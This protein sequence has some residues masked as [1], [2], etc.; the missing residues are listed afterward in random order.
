[1]QLH[2]KSDPLF[3]KFWMV[4]YWLIPQS[5]NGQYT[6]IKITLKI[7]PKWGGSIPSD[8]K[9]YY[10][11]LMNKIVLGKILT[12]IDIAT[13]ISDW[14]GYLKNVNNMEKKIMCY[15]IKKW[16]L[17]VVNI[18]WWEIQIILQ[19]KKVCLKFSDIIL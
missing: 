15:I 13:Y 14:T 19:K 8:V 2:S 6:K 7:R 9:R 12:L 10:R 16:I 5:N 4:D 11:A 3:F 1:M 18:K 17:I